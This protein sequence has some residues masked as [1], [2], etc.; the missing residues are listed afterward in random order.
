MSEQRPPL[1]IHRDIVVPGDFPRP[2]PLAAI[3][4]RLLGLTKLRKQEGTAETPEDVVHRDAFEASTSAVRSEEI[5]HIGNPIDEIIIN[6]TT[7]NSNMVRAWM[8][9]RGLADYEDGPIS[10]QT[11]PSPQVPGA[12]VSQDSR[13]VELEVNVPDYQL[14]YALFRDSTFDLRIDFARWETDYILRYRSGRQPIHDG[15]TVEEAEVI[16]SYL[17]YFLE[18]P[19]SFGKKAA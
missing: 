9:T 18:T 2:Y 14:T 12:R 3:Q 19:R 5:L 13:V 11:D 10:V 4:D 17:Q 1:P 6:A 16:G 7:I 8:D 15:M